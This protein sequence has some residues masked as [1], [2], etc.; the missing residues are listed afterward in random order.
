LI[1]ISLFRIEPQDIEVTPLAQL[2]CTGCSNFLNNYACPLYTP[3][4]IY[5][6]GILARAKT[7][8]AVVAWFDLASRAAKTWQKVRNVKQALTLACLQ[9]ESYSRRVLDR[10]IRELVARL[11]DDV[12]MWLH[13]GG[14]C[15]HCRTCRAAESRPCASPR[16]RTPPS[17]EGLGVDLYGTLRKYGVYIEHPPRR[18]V[19]KVGLILLKRNITREELEKLAGSKFAVEENAEP[20]RPDPRLEHEIRKLEEEDRRLLEE[21]LRDAERCEIEIA[22]REC[23]SR[24]CPLRGTAKCLVVRKYF[25]RIR[26]WRAEVLLVRKRV[27]PAWLRQSYMRHI[28]PLCLVMSDRVHV[29]RQGCKTVYTTLCS[30]VLGLETELAVVSRIEAVKPWLHS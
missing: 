21:V 19:T 6:P 13:P 3:H 2:S 7:V 27:D 28:A 5:T 17:P 23:S 26:D 8:I 29:R 9:L 10:H 18:V 22:P 14:G 12:L 25:E 1:R 4:A 16:T 20:P 11:G 24:T 15:R 30:C